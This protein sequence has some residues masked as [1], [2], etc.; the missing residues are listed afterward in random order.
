MV[1]G[2]LTPPKSIVSSSEAAYH[3]SAGPSDGF[4]PTTPTRLR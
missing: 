1:W 3:K 4:A 2:G